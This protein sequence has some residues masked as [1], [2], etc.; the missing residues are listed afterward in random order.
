MRVME[1]YRYILYF[2]QY[3]VIILLGSV[4]HTLRLQSAPVGGSASQTRNRDNRTTWWIKQMKLL[5]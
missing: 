4:F 5:N 3:D 2:K 1:K